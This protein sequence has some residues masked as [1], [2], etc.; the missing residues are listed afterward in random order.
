L[1]DDNARL[2]SSPKRKGSDDIEAYESPLPRWNLMRR[3]WPQVWEQITDRTEQPHALL[4]RD[5]IT[6]HLGRNASHT[7]YDNLDLLMGILQQ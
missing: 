1:K 5:Y 3:N 7:I 4:L 2:K 6:R